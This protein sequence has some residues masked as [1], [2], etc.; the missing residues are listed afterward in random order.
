MKKEIHSCTDVLRSGGTI[1]YPTDTIWGIGCDATNPDAV[2]KIYA[3]KKREDSKAMLVLADSLEMVSGYVE[4]IPAIA[5]DILK[6]NE[7][8]LTIIYPGARGLANNLV[9]EDGSIGIRITEEGFSRGLIRAFGKPIVSSSA[10]LAGQ[11][12][13]TLY[14]EI[15][16]DIRSAVDYIADW[17]RDERGKRKPSGILKVD[18]NGEIKVIR[19]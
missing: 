13:P 19:K 8:P 15:S 4:E 10:N 6:I 9:S 14:A 2:A 18:L 16:M 12:P 7:K 3:I 1:L 5:L 17:N 11:S